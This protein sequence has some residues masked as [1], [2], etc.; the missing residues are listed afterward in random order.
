[1]K[2]LRS[3][4]CL[5]KCNRNKPFLVANRFFCDTGVTDKK[6]EI[7]TE[8]NAKQTQQENSSEQTT[9]DRYSVEN[10]LNNGII[11]TSYN[12]VCIITIIHG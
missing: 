5:L 3:A 1:M 2:L 12:E 8:Q 10:T 11:I 6:S 9:S 4:F 7:K